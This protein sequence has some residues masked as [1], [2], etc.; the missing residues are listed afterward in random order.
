MK[1]K[2]IKKTRVYEEVVKQLKELIANGELGP[3]EKLPSERELA[4]QFGVSRVSIRQALTVLE[5]LGLIER[6]IGGGTFSVAEKLDF[7]IDPVLDT[8]I[9]NK[10]QLREPLEMRRILE[11]NLAQLAAERATEEDIR[12]LEDSLRK[13]KELI[14]KG[15]L[16][17]DEDSRFHYYLAKA[18]NNEIALKI[19]EVMH[20][21]IWQT[22]E[23]SIKAAQGSELSYRGHQRI[24]RAVKTR[25]GEKAFDAMLDHLEEVEALI[26]KH[27]A[28]DR[29]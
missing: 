14:E 24:L 3:G 6:K 20:D 5:T 22:R 12:I 8:I 28:E 19:V 2:T 15:E 1:I 17:I 25:N 16:I 18:A 21:M 4:K 7:D 26:M 27:L 11:P 23:K 29:N 10:D 13:Q 9:K